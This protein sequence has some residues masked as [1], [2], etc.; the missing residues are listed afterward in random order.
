[1][2]EKEAQEQAQ[3]AHEKAARDREEA[4]Q[5]AALEYDRTLAGIREEAASKAELA[6][7]AYDARVQ[8]A[9]EAAR[10]AEKAAK[11]AAKETRKG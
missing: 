3:R 9:D 10:E 6:R 5:A 2:D 4:V 7:G 8:A 1:M 11:A